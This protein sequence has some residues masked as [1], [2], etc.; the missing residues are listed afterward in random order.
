MATLVLVVHIVSCVFLI[1]FVLL[2]AGKGAE[3]GATLGNLGQTYFGSQTGNILT[4]ITTVIAFLFMLTSIGLTVLQHKE[5]SSS[6][7]ESK[8]AKTVPAVPAAA[9]VTV[10][11]QPQTE[12]AKQAK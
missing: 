6:I 11:A 5:V 4:K 8:V 9:P 7:M 2:Q 12:P 3:L 10:P 1:L